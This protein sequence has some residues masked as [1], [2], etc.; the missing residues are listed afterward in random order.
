[1]RKNK[2]VWY[3]IG[4]KAVFRNSTGNTFDRYGYEHSDAQTLTDYL[5][6]RG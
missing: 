6:T 4:N 3:W 1:M 5:N 2:W